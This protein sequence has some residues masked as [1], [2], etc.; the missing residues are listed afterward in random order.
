[1]RKFYKLT[2]NEIAQ[3]EDDILTWFRKHPQDEL[4]MCD[5]MFFAVPYLDK[6]D[7]ALLVHSL[8][9]RGQLVRKANHQR[10]ITT[11]SYSLPKAA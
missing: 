8:V 2:A 3:A 6:A 10:Y 11:Y 1:M 7:T 4:V 5:V 9:K